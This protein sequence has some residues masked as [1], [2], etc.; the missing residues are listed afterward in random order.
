MSRFR[1]RHCRGQMFLFYLAA[2]AVVFLLCGLGLDISLMNL[3]QARL[4]R[5]CDAAVISGVQQA[6]PVREISLVIR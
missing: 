2:F 5:A 3:S 4:S 1:R 6:R